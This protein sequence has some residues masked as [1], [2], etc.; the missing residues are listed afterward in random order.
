MKKYRIRDQFLDHLRKIPIVQ[1]AC[2][3]SGVSRSSVYR[4][5][6][7]DEDFAKAMDT[8]IAEGEEYVSDLS[9]SQLL[10]LIKEKNWSAISFWLRHRSPKYKDKIEVTAH[11]KTQEKLSPEQ[12]EVV[13]KALQMAS[14]LPDEETNQLS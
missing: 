11:I 9:E 12:E 2:E 4:W 7:D 6:E 14:I 13:R 1:V 10:T 3:K 8:A 5:R